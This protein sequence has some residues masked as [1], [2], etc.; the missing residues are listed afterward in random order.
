MLKG[1]QAGLNLPAGKM[2]PSFAAL[3]D[4]GNTSCSTTWYVL[5]YMESCDKVAKSHRIMQVSGGVGGWN[6]GSRCAGSRYLAHIFN[7]LV[8]VRSSHVTTAPC[9]CR[10]SSQ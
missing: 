5:A 2:L 4:Y 10:G 3:R 9:C 7:D 6:Q 8:H 1:I